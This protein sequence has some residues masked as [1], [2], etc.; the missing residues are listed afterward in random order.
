MSTETTASPSPS[1]VEVIKA[2]SRNLRGTLAESLR[3]SSTGAIAPDDTQISKFHG[4]YQQD[5]RDLRLE[6]R[7]QKLERAFSFMIRVR[8][9]GGVCTPAQYRLLDD[10]AVKRGNGTIRLT[11]RQAFQLHGILKGNLRPLI[12]AMHT[13]LMHSIGA[14]GDINRNVMCHSIPERS[15]VHAE[16]YETACAISTHLLPRSRAYHEIWLEDECV[17]GGEPE[18]EPIYG[19]TYLPRKFKIGVALPPSNDVDIFSQDLGFIAIADAGRILGYNVVAGGGLGMTHGNAATYPKLAEVLGFCFPDQVLAVAEAVVTTQRDHGDRSNRK[20][21]RL[22]Y[23]IEDMGLDAFRAEVERRSGVAFAPARPYR[24]DRIADEYGWRQAADGSWFYTQF[25]Q[26]GRIAD[27][28]GSPLKTALRELADLDR[29]EFR[30]TP[31]QNLLIAGLTDEDKAAAT[32]IL[33]RHGLGDSHR[34]TGL[35]LNALSCPALPTC[36]LALAE[37]E[38]ALPGL[39]EPLE[40]VLR[41]LGLEERPISIRMTGCPNGCAR[42]Y[43]GEIGI[44]GKAPGKYNLYVGAKYNGTRLNREVGFAL[45]EDKLVETITGWLRRYAAEAESG[46]EFGDFAERVQLGAA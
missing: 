15:P 39:L 20:H 33:G 35:R 1:P 36:G 22:K 11:T 31:S 6:R 43:L 45:T 21:A 40:A 32:A 3:D 17:A 42:P 41:E 16:I 46:E 30:L 5:D 12:Q 7:K 26:S 25:I 19:K 13:E 28:P 10:L 4:L 29:G 27:T 18:E 34:Q 37:S 14:C 9:S 23:T 44:V 8:V 24:F 38:R 2:N